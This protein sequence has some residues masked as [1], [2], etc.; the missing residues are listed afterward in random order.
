MPPKGELAL[1]SAQVEVIRAWIDAGAPAADTSSAA[2]DNVAE[3]SAADRDYWAFRGPLRRDPPAVTPNDR[4]RTPVDAFLAAKLADRDL[5]FA[6][7]ADRQTLVRRVFFDLIGLPPTPAEVDEFVNDTSPAAYDH[8]V[9]RLLASPYFGER[10]GRHWLDASGY[11]DVYGGDNDAGII[12]LA[13][14]KWRYRDYVIRSFNEDKP[15]DRFLT[16]QLAGDELEDW[17]SVQHFSP[18]TLDHLIAT[19]FLR[20][21][22]MTPTKT[23]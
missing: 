6:P 20:T 17:R 19:T 22:P 4:I 13:E 8:L 7:D 1:T 21:A 18:A 12:K 10:W 2:D 3:T 5:S 23:S 16:E 9:D 15:F 14:G 11:V